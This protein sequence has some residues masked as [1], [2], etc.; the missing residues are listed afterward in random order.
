MIAQTEKNKLIW[1]IAFQVGMNVSWNR[2]G[3]IIPPFF[4]F[5]I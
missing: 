1:I 5:E 2:N 3:Y 4:V